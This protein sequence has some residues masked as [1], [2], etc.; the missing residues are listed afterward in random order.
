[1]AYKVIITFPD[2]TIDSEEEDGPDG[3]FDTEEEAREYFN[4]WMSNYAAGGE[5]LHMSNPG[6]YP[7]E[8]VEQEPEYEIV[9]V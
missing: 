4:E 9:E 3:V 8:I 5:V 7:L 2:D 1:M 6:D